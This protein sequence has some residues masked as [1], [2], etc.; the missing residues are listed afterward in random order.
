MTFLHTFTI[1]KQQIKT[2]NSCSIDKQL[3]LI[4]PFINLF[5]YL[6]L[7]YFYSASSSHPLSEALPTTARTLCWSFHAKAHRAIVSEELAQCPTWHLGRG[8]NPWRSGRRQ[9][10]LPTVPPL[11]TINQRSIVERT[12]NYSVSYNLWDP[13]QLLNLTLQLNSKFVGFLWDQFFF[14]FFY[15]IFPS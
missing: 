11:L 5:H 4:R 15:K 8:S 1:Q 9:T 7:N 3:L 2:F 10:H 6:F 12:N 14:S 13:N